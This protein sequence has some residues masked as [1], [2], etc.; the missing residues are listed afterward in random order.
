[1]DLTPENKEIID[2]MDYEQLLRQWRFSPSGDPW[3]Q[4]ETGEYWSKRMKELKGPDH[5]SISKK[6]GW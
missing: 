6:I 3:I 4:G 2:N 1:M 5:T